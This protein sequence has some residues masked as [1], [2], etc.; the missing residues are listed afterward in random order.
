MANMKNPI[1]V[2]CAC[3]VMAM[4]FAVQ[5][6]TVREIEWDDLIPADFSFESLLEGFDLETFDQLEDDDPRAL[7]MYDQLMALWQEAPVVEALDGQVVRLPGFV[8]PLDGD[9]RNVR[10]FLLVPYYGACIHVPP[11]PANQTVHVLS[12][13]RDVRIRGLFD[14]VWVTGVIRVEHKSSDMAESGY[15]IDVIEVTPYNE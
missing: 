3:A 9:G 2:I 15:Q 8:V 12:P 11:P 10:E 7:E 13:D 6:N 1:L 5:A 4:L 14:T